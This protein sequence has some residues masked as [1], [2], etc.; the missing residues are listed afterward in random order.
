VTR[1]ES[2]LALL[3]ARLE[4]DAAG[5]REI[6]SLL[7]GGLD[8]NALAGACERHG[9]APLFERHLREVGGATLSK[10]TRGAL[11]ARAEATSRRN[12]ALCSDLAEVVATLDRH[13]IEAVPYKGPTLALSAYHDVGLREFGDLDLLLRARDVLRAK[14]ALAPLGYVPAHALSPDQEVAL[15]ASPR[16]YELPLIDAGRGRIVELHWRADPDVAVPALDDESWWRSLPSVTVAGQSMRSL[17]PAQLLLVLCLH[18]SKHFW[19]SLGWL[20]DVAELVRGNR[21]LDWEWLLAEGR[22]HQCRRRLALGLHLASEL[23]AAPVPESVLRR[24]DD[25]VVMQTARRIEARLFDPAARPFGIAQA[26]WLNVCLQDGAVARARYAWR[27][28]VTPGW[29]EWVRWRLP[30]ALGFLY[31]PLRFARLA[32]K[33]AA[34]SRL[35]RIATRETVLPPRLEHDDRDGVREIQAAIPGSHR[36]P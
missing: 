16:C 2:R 4:I 34:P 29:G 20:V 32:A 17:P 8:W 35:W 3:L 5:R 23:L 18:G 7:A 33:Y 21:D 1:R 9:L 19:W 14:A 6:D 30:P 26:L 25:R 27:A 10:Q 12:R 36:K 11:W 22:R 13:G 28:A 31:L 24:M 15:L